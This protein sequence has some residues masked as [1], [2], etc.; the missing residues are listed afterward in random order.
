MI[1]INIQ[2]KRNIA[3]DTL[4]RNPRTDEAMIEEKIKLN[5]I[6]T[7]L[8]NKQLIEKMRNIAQ[9]QTK[10]KHIKKMKESEHLTKMNGIIVVRHK[11]T[12]RWKVVIPSHLAKDLII[13]THANTGHPGRFKTYHALKDTCTFQNMQK[14]IAEVIKNCDLCQRNKPINYNASGK[15]ISHKPTKPLEK[16]S[17]DMM[18]PL[19][20]GRGGTHYILA[21]LYV[22]SKYIR[23]Y[24]IKRA[25]TKSIINK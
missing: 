19:P 4:T 8:I 17:I 10:D 2:G 6:S 14:L 9:E 18:G 15:S 13:E 1:I 24:A 11:I 5:K 20:T 7:L 16:V 22:F 23:L 25:T 21:I 3:A 12:D